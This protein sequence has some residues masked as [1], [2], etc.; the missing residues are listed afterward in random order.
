MNDNRGPVVPAGVILP[1][2]TAKAV[3][4][5]IVLAGMLAAANAYLGLFAG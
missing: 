2:I 3:I 1:E 5:S 4:L